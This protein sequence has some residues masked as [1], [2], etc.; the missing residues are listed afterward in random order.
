MMDYMKIIVNLN[1]TDS[2]HLNNV[3]MSYYEHFKFSLK[4]SF[5]FIGGFIGAFIHAIFPQ[6]LIK[7]STE[8]NKTLNELLKFSNCSKI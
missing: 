4:L 5:Y 7:S 8:I 2:N 6:I 3:C 1:M